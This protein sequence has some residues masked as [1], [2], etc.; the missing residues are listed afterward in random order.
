MIWGGGVNLLE[1]NELFEDDNVESLWKQ[2]D[3]SLVVKIKQV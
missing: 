2:I 1:G 3:Y